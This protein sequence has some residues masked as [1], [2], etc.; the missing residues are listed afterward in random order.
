MH[1][2]F[3]IDHLWMTVGW[4]WEEWVN[5]LEGEPSA[6][7]EVRSTHYFIKDISTL[8]SFPSI[9]TH[10][11]VPEKHPHSMMLRSTLP[12]CWEVLDRWW[13]IPAVLQTRRLELKPNSSISVSSDQRIL[14]LTDHRVM[15]T[16][17]TKALL[18]RLLSI[19]GRPALG[20]ALA[21]PNFFHLRIMEVTMCSWEPAM[22]QTFSK[23]WLLSLYC[24]LQLE[25]RSFFKF[26]SYGLLVLCANKQFPLSWI[27]FSP[28]TMSIYLFLMF[29]LSLLDSRNGKFPLTLIYTDMA[30]KP[31]LNK[32]HVSAQ[33]NNKALF[34]PFQHLFPHPHAFFKVNKLFCHSDSDRGYFEGQ[35]LAIQKPGDGKRLSEAVVPMPHLQALSG[36]CRRVGDCGSV[37]RGIS[38]LRCYPRVIQLSC[39]LAPCR[40][41]RRSFTPDGRGWTPSECLSVT[42]WLNARS[43]QDL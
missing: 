27:D 20:R 43:R 19:S 5:L 32:T 13:E 42:H 30:W 22:Q 33:R 17:P 6:Q 14:F 31:R 12:Q 39:S 16:S 8:F 36:V 23:K 25:M 21:A 37:I 11:P 24:S 28:I 35:P 26:Y 15:V 3:Y 7:S 40:S 38:Q 10:H 4:H 9:L 41:Q 1:K 34:R 18:P 29:T 2:P